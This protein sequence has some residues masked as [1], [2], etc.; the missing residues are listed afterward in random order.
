ME[1]CTPPRGKRLPIH[2]AVVDEKSLGL[3][4]GHDRPEL[5]YGPCGGGVLRYLP[6]HDPFGK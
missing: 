3:I 2:V 5:L 1:I 6:M 4:A